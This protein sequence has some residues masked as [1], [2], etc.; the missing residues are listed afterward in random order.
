MAEGGTVLRKSKRTVYEKIRALYWDRYDAVR[1]KKATERV[2][3]VAAL[4]TV[5]SAGASS[6]A[7]VPM[8]A[9]ADA[10]TSVLP[11]AGQTATGISS[12]G[13]TV[14]A[15]GPIADQ[16]P[17]SLMMV[18]SKEGRSK[19][20]G[21]IAIIKML[22]GWQGRF[23]AGGVFLGL[24][25]FYVKEAAGI[26]E[27]VTKAPLLLTLAAAFI[28][29]IFLKR[30]LPFVMLLAAI[31]VVIVSKL[32]FINVPRKELAWIPG[33]ALCLLAVLYAVWRGFRS[34]KSTERA[35]S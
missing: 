18:D 7:T 31:A 32:Q 19:T 2:P 26:R 10:K 20:L 29:S 28:L 13:R 24:Y 34:L 8:Q 9:G 25:L 14:T 3:E 6:A 23:M 27:H 16:L 12:A 21:P 22:L 5:V 30:G 4:A 1:E 33:L 11:N 35:N 17:T 15:P